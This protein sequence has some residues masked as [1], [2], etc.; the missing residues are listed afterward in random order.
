[1]AKAA[2]LLRELVDRSIPQTGDLGLDRR[3]ILRKVSGELRHLCTDRTAERKDQAEG[4]HDGKNDGQDPPEPY[5]PQQFHQRAQDKAQQHRQS[6]RDQNLAPEIKGR[7]YNGGDL[8]PYRS[9][10]SEG[11]FRC[12]LG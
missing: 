11:S 4:Q 1:M 2:K 8:D 12:N 6:D 7:H 5:P 3:L 10:Q 9:P